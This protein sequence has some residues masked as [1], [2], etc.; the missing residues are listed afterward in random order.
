MKI[1]MTE[2][3]LH[4]SYID[5]L[6][7]AL[8]KQ[9]YKVVVEGKI[10]QYGSKEWAEPDI[11]VLRKEDESLI[12]DK[13]IEVTLCDLKEGPDS[14]TLESKCKRIKKYY[15]PPEIIVFEPTDYTTN[16][17]SLS[18]G[19]F[20]HYDDYNSYLQEKWKKEGLNVTFWN[21]WNLW[22]LQGVQQDS[23]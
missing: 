15:N 6:T 18:L 9:G 2:K 10:P 17:Y 14:R 13:I 22:E 23:P 19:R 8:E 4:D 21:E 7:E 5:K 12:L 20:A 16:Y 1:S 11:F 3:R